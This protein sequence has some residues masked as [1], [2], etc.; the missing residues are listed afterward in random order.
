M[1]AVIKNSNG[2]NQQ[3]ALINVPSEPQMVSLTSS[4]L[5]PSTFSFL[6]ASAT[7]PSL[8]SDESKIILDFLRNRDSDNPLFNRNIPAAERFKQGKKY[9]GMKM[10]KQHQ[11]LNELPNSAEKETLLSS[12]K[13]ELEGIYELFPVLRERSG[14]YAATLSGGEQQQ[15]AIARALVSSPKLPLVDEV[16]MG[17][18]P[19]LAVQV[20]EVLRTLNK[21]KGLTILLV[22]QNVRQALKIAD[23]AYVMETG[24]IVLHGKAAEIIHDPRVMEAYLGGRHA[25]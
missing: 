6:N 25:V 24:K 21:E 14:Q 9:V 23:Y 11:E 12:L 15:L 2:T 8:P 1:G 16:S 17:L 13:K 10:T 18:M 19:K 22:E 7:L 3:D 20:F 5:P 4:T